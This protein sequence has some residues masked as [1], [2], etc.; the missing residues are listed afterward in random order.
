MP[1]VLST[2]LPFN[3]YLLV[4][5]V[6][7]VRAEGNMYLD[8]CISDDLV[9]ETSCGEGSSYHLGSCL[10]GTRATQLLGKVLPTATGHSSVVSQE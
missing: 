8:A 3:F 10:L 7:P 4:E 9:E 5:E 6:S 2:S 1:A